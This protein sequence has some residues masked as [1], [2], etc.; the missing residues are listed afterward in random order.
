VILAGTG[1]PNDARDSY[2]GAGILRSAD[3]GTT[4]SLIPSTP[5][6]STPVYSFDGE[7]FAGFAWSTVN[8]DLVVAA[9]SQAYDAT[10]VNAAWPGVSYEGLY[11]STDGGATWSLATITDG[12]GGDVQGPEDAFVSPDGNAATSVV[13]NPVRNLFIAAVRYHGYYQSSDGKTFTR[14]TDQP[15][16]KL[17]FG[18]S[19]PEQF[20]CPTNAGGSTGSTGCPIFRGALAVN[21]TTGDTFAWTVDE[22]NQDQGIWQDVCSASGGA[23][24]S[25][26]VTFAQQ[27]GTAAL[28]TNTSLGAATIENGDYNL[29]LAAVPSGQETMLLAGAN[30]LWQTNCPYSQGCRWRNTTNS[31]T[32]MSAGVGEYQHALAWNAS[33]PLEIFV[34]NDSGLWRSED[35]ISESTLAAPEPVCS[36]TDASHFQNL[37]GSL[38][39][40]ADVA[41]ISQAGATPYTMM[42]GLGANGTAGVAST[43]AATADWPEI[44]GG[45]GGPVAIDPVTPTNW[46]V[47]NAAGVSIYLNTEGSTPGAFSPV[48]NVTTDPGA[49][50][51]TGA[52]VVRDGLSMAVEPPYAPAAFL[53]DPLDSTKLL[54]GTCRVWRGPANGVGWSAANAISDILDGITGD[55]DC[56]GNALIRSMAALALPVRR[57]CPR[58]ARWSTWGCTARR[59][60]ARP[61]PATCCARPTTRHRQLVCLDG[62]DGA[63]RGHQRHA[64]DELLRAGHLQHLH[65]PAGHHRRDGLRDRGGDSDAVGG[66]ADGLW[67]DRRRGALDGFDRQPALGSGQQP[68]GGPCELQYGLRRH[69]RRSLRHAGDQLLHKCRRWLLGPAGKRAAGCAGGSSSAPRRPPPACII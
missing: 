23:C 44:L 25:P 6:T 54:I 35:G 19:A 16:R 22:Y 29:A 8:A 7:G 15:G 3:G 24:A 68:G 39:S 49:L 37:N 2:Y 10:L 50:T 38:G 41:S 4:W 46:Y 21:P 43:T 63:E 65:R 58:A 60:A 32:C 12:S 69:R 33:N 53:V 67:L 13:W 28:E 34:G 56:M 31:T 26:T 5:V 27:W 9:V 64:H 52:D 47:N 45:E 62:R 20:W 66:G 51:T 55:D 36:A 17:E 11:Y 1:D 59:M 18:D 42:A 61:C 40:L 57:R 14:L 30:D 48:L